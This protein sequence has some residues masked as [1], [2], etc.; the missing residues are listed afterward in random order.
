MRLS[1]PGIGMA[2]VHGPSPA[3]AI[4]Y[5]SHHFAMTV[6]LEHTIPPLRAGTKWPST[7]LGDFDV[8]EGMLNDIENSVAG[9][10]RHSIQSHCFFI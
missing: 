3:A 1:H 4:S 9:K 7:K 8:P 2:A 10:I 5:D 6:W